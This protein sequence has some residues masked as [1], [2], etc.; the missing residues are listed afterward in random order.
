MRVIFHHIPKSAGTSVRATI[1]SNYRRGEIGELYEFER[2][3]RHAGAI[4][5]YYKSLGWWRRRRTKIFCGHAAVSLVPVLEPPFRCFTFLREPVD[6]VLSLFHF[7]MEHPGGGFGKPRIAEL[8]QEIDKPLDQVLELTPQLLSEDPVK[9]RPLWAFFNGQIRSLMR[10][11]PKVQSAVGY[12]RVLEDELHEQALALI[13][14]HFILGF[15]EQFDASL[16]HVAQELDWQQAEPKQENI[17]Q[18]RPK[19]D[20]VDPELVRRIEEANQLDVRFY[21]DCQAASP[22]GR[23]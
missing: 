13:E 4:G 15:Q 16:R 1:K 23:A 21:R 9:H 17:T 11:H 12:D 20:S 5:E 14:R 19:R 10:D 3:H 2:D 7:A 22:V 18:R 6:R 8:L